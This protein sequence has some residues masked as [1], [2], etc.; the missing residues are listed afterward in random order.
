M[1]ETNCCYKWNIVKGNEKVIKSLI[2]NDKKETFFS[3]LEKIKYENLDF[4]IADQFNLRFLRRIYF[5]DSSFETQKT[6]DAFLNKLL[7]QGV[8]LT[9]LDLNNFR[10]R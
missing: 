2:L 4:L 6:F 9:K 5:N 3:G 10:I 7:E 8:K 1:E